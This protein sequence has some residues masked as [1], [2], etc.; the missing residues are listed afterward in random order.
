MRE[1]KFRITW[2]QERIN[3]IIRHA[4]WL[5]EWG[6]LKVAGLLYACKGEHTLFTGQREK[7]RGRGRETERERERLRKREKEKERERE[8]EKEGERERDW[9]RGRERERKRKYLFLKEMT[10]ALVPFSYSWHIFNKILFVCR[11]KTMTITRESLLRGSLCT[12]DLL[13]L[14]SRHHLLL[15]P[16]IFIY[17]TPSSYLH[18]EVNCT[19][20]P[21]Q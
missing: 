1:W 5:T 17:F 10:G 4:D 11:F 6:T 2:N 16:N 13:V 7:E 9:E 14:T 21:L 20:P 8:T 18:E 15:I 12:N 3:V 19:E